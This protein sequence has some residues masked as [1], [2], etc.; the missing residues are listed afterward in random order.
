MNMHQQDGTAPDA[1]DADPNDESVQCSSPPCFAG[2]VD[3]GYFMAE[4]AI[5][6]DELL[7][8]LNQLLAAERA[9]A[10]T[11]GHFLRGL[12]AGPVR[13]ALQ[14]TG[15]DEGRYTAMLRQQIERLGGAPTAETGAFFNKAIAI[16][17]LAERLAFL[18]RGQGWVA[19]ELTKVLPRVRD[20]ELNAA[21]TEMRDTHIVNIRTCT[22]AAEAM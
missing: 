20:P 2:E 9:G 13:Q 19:R 1:D 11:I 21:L 4:P 7:A 5:P 18:N 16:E 15:R 17:G 22:E 12:D 8:L 6:P 3:P 10:K 14:H